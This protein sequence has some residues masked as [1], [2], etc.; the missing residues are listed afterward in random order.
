M[1]V[2]L[3]IL[4]LLSLS[5]SVVYMFVL[6]KHIKKIREG[7]HDLQKTVAELS[8]NIEKAGSSL[9]NIKK[10]A[11]QRGRDLE[12]LIDQATSIIDEMN[13]IN[14][15]SDNV[16]ERL[17]KLVTQGSAVV[18]KENEKNIRSIRKKVVRQ[19][20]DK[21]APEKENI[22]EER[23]SRK[24]FDPPKKKPRRP[25]RGDKDFETDE[26]DSSI[27]RSERDLVDA[28]KKRFRDQE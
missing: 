14:K 24:A 10:I 2:V 4:V 19:E 5:I 22:K 12:R 9:D 18:E 3:D 13:F 17:G 26:N 1:L 15:A 11:D 28:I 20:I 21:T 6:T 23:E 27:S 7:K 25:L 8:A 16:A